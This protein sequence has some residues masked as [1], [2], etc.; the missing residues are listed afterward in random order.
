MTRDGE[1]RKGE[2]L[3]EVSL[4]RTDQAGEVVRVVGPAGSQL[5]TEKKAHKGN[6]SKQANNCRVLTAS[7]LLA[8]ATEQLASL[9]MVELA[10]KS[11]TDPHLPSRSNTHAAGPMPGNDSWLV[12][13]TISMI[14]NVYMS[15]R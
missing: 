7:K 10:A 8:T 11:L 4:E 13:G 14:S 12:A 5:A 15:C 2:A 3:R 6:M 1:E 9:D